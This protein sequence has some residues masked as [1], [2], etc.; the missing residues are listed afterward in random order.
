VNNP[1]IE[2]IARQIRK[3]VLRMH[4]TGSNVGGAMSAADILAVLYFDVMRILSPNDPARDRFIMSKGHC[5]SALYSA[6]SQK[7]FFDRSRLDE[8]CVDGRPLTGHPSRGA[9]P[10]IEA[11]SGSLGHGLPMAVGMAW[12]AMK[13]GLPWRTYVLMGDGECQEGSVWE[14]ATAA[15]RLQLDN[16]AAIVDANNLQGYGRCE[17]IQPIETLAAKFEAFGWDAR[18][19]DGHDC[20]ALSRALHATPFA[21]GKPS[22]VIAKTIK[23]KGVREMEDI[24]G[25]HYFSVPEEKLPRFL[26]ELDA[27]D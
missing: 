13:D 23:G 15:A 5:V 9:V 7:S 6:L 8:Y 22:A 18:V 4:R 3:D 1:P 25:W 10:G 21:P 20:A 2:A 12:A 27:K 17:D 19:V 26:D 14:G 16:L 24:L 11:S